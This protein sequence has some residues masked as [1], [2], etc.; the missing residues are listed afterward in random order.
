M[1]K[2]Q[3][4]MFDVTGKIETSKDFNEITVPEFCEAIRAR[5][6]RLEQDNEIEAFGFCDSYDVDE[7]TE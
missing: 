6:N 2:L 3:N 1:S 4:Y 5:L 7:Q